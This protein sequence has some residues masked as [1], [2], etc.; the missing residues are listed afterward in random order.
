MREFYRIRGN[1]AHGKLDTQ[2]PAAWNP[3]EHLVLAT[4]AFPLLVKSLLNKACECKLAN[5]D[6]TQ[7][8]VFENLADT[9]DFLKPPPNQKG[10]IDSHWK[11]LVGARSNKVA[12]E[13]AYE[14]AWDNL[15]PEHRRCFEGNLDEETE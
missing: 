1:F 10:S 2:Q 5:D 12:M 7:I 14:Q 4:I 9:T 15:T 3:L 11:R 13:C 8:D 6:R